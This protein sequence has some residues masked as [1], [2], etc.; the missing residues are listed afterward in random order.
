VLGL[1]VFIRLPGATQRRNGLSELF[2]IDGGKIRSIYAT[3][4]YPP[5]AA[6]VPNWPPYVGNW[7]IS[8]EQGRH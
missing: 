3:M 7:P 1:V 5:G 8:A 6:P 4:F 2:F